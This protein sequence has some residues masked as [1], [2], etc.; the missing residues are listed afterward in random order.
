MSG[1]RPH[2]GVQDF[3]DILSHPVAGELP[4]LVGG[5]A[6]NLWASV[7]GERIGRALDRWLPLVSKDLDLFGGLSLLEGMRERF[8]GE[9]RLSGPRS[10]VVGQL[11]VTAGGKEL[12]IDVLR[13]VVGLR[14]RD[15]E[16]ESDTVEIAV[17][18][19]TCTVRVL[20][21]LPLFRAKI[22]NLATLDQED[23]NDFKH[24]ALMLL[25]AREY[26]S[27]MIGAVESGE[28]GSRPVIDRLE[29]ALEIVSTR[30]AAA[31]TTRY[32]VDFTSLWPQAAKDPRLGNFVKHRLPSS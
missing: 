5:H 3:R 8:G 18:G 31:C 10:P 25:V 13:E 24:V 11:V 22:A 12:K 19:E 2:S 15:L 9:F 20:P 16:K 29:E 28:A 21:V 23:R 14:R 17:S 32:G 26:L 4:L 7:Y 1:S 27:M 6:V 30:E